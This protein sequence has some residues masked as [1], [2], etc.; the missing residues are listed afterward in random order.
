MRSIFVVYFFVV[1]MM[2][3]SFTASAQGSL[4]DPIYTED[5][6]SGPSPGPALG[7]KTNMTYTTGCPNDGYYSIVSSIDN[8]NNCHLDTWQNLV[9][10]HTGNPNGYMMWINATINPPGTP[11]NVFFTYT[12]PTGALCPETTYQFSVYICNLI[13]QSISAGTINPRITFVISTPDGKQ[14]EQYTTPDI[15]PN[16]PS[17]SPWQLYAT[18]AFALPAGVTNV[19]VTMTNDANGGNG[20]DLVLDDI[21]FR[22]YGPAISAGFNSV[23]VTTPVQA[24]TGDPVSF[25]LVSSIPANSYTAP[26]FQ[27]QQNIN[28]G[29]WTDIPGATSANLPQNFTP[30]IGTYQYRIGVAEAANI[31]S[32]K[33]RVYS[34]PLQVIVS[35]KILAPPIIT[36]PTQVCEGQPF[37]LSA[38]ATGGVT[39]VWTKPDKS[40]STDNPL[41]IP[42]ASPADGGTYTVV[43]Y[44]EN[45]CPSPPSNPV[46]VAVNPTPVITATADLTICE[47][48]NTNLHA[49]GGVSYSWSPGKTLSD[50]TMSNPVA[51]PADNITYKVTVT[52]KNGCTDTTSVNINVLK[53]PIANAGPDKVI[54]EGQSVKLTATAQYADVFSWTPTTGLSDPNILNPIAN[55]TDDI[56]YTLHATSTQNC[57]TSTDEVFVK[58]YKKITIPNSFSPNGDGINDLWN[59]DALIT[60]PQSIMTVFNRYGQQVYRDIGYSK[61][62]N[63][64]YNGEQVPTGTYY[65]VLDLKNNTPLMTGWVVVVR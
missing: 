57:G 56:T 52:D 28:N 36:A 33:C 13:K 17:Q 16:D 19:V 30:T 15:L 22:A 40:T 62:W 34:P 45:N 37:T 48:T 64:K 46:Q 21:T 10:D 65:Y 29:I 51:T 20:N 63:G 43:A 26:A 31:T 2:A 23:N 25:T 42:A 59:I 3:M 5:F 6:G 49:T 61:P 4:G 14:L 12:V 1:V 8:T 11:P 50:S 32:E 9:H 53:A 55:P 39:Y 38:T 24:C 35:P 18:P 47:G 27:W 7:A 41:I 54:F 44:N 60:Y 58:V